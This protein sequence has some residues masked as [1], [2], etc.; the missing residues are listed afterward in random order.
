MSANT[1]VVSEGRNSVPTQAPTVGMH[2]LVPSV[3][4][5]N[6]SIHPTNAFSFSSCFAPAFRSALLYAIK[7]SPDPDINTQVTICD[8]LWDL[9]FF[10]S[11][12][13]EF[14]KV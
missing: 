11:N 5:H 8:T 13:Y 7:N 6:D 10:F 1:N 3:V 14:H 9:Q 12:N 2:V 4:L